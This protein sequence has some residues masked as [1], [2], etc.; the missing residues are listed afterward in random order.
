MKPHVNTQGAVSENSLFKGELML[1]QHMNIK[2]M[3]GMTGSY[4]VQ[5][6]FPSKRL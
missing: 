5:H 3:N 4:W 6:I 1:C 2:Q